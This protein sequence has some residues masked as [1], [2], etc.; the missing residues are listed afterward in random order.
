MKEFL[1]Q[2]GVNVIE[3]NIEE[4]PKAQEELQQMGF[5]AIPVTLIGE[6]KIV[7]FNRR[8]LEAALA[9]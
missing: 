7:G 8:A 6:Q 3:K 1:S 5:F 9:A 2:K 4:D